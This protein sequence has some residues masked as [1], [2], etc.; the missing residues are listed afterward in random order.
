MLK[1]KV[2]LTVTGLLYSSTASTSWQ[3]SRAAGRQ[4]GVPR[5]YFF[6]IR[7]QQVS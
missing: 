3:E 4:A 7:K 2:L 6:G 1:K 5:S